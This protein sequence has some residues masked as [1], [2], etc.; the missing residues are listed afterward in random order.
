M[1]FNNL[2]YDMVIFVKMVKGFC[3]LGRIEDTCRLVKIVKQRCS[4]CCYIFWF[5]MGFLEM[6]SIMTVNAIRRE[7]ESE[8]LGCIIQL[9]SHTH[10]WSVKVSEKGRIETLVNALC[11]NGL[12]RPAQMFVLRMVQIA[13]NISVH[14][15]FGVGLSYD[16][17]SQRGL[18]IVGYN[19]NQR[20]L[21]FKWGN[22]H[23]IS[24]LPMWNV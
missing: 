12:V 2:H 20:L 9:F 1:S 19:V 3:S 24:L 10:Q 17:W 4:K 22:F 18:L 16:M 13:F 15:L 6:M 21:W 11:K 23:N 7:K 5:F 14:I 8:S